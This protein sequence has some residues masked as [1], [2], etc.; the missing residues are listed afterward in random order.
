MSIYVR[1]C[2]K[3]GEGYDIGT[4]YDIC[5]SC[6]LKKRENQKFKIK[7]GEGEDDKI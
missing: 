5:S 7:F 2:R 4:N 6:R 3:C 1:F